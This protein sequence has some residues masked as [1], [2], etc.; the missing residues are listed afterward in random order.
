[1]RTDSTFFDCFGKNKV[2]WHT[3]QIDSRS[4]AI[5][6]KQQIAQR[7]DVYGEDSD[8]FKV[9][10]RGEFPAAGELLRRERHG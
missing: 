7:A 5:S 9:H 4:V 1:M 3:K 6:N 10:V 8:W 2:V